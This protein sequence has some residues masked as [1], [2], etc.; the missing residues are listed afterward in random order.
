[1]VDINCESRHLAVPL[2]NMNHRSVQ[3]HVLYWR[4]PRV[5][6][7][8]GPQADSTFPSMS[9]IPLK[10]ERC[11]SKMLTQVESHLHLRERALLSAV[12]KVR[13]W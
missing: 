12:P 6:H 5:G 3:G 9:L 13:M 1:M 10:Q 2:V 4:E 7:L 8:A 11:K